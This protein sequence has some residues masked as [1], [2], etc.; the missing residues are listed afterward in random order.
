MA[1]DADLDQPEQPVGDKQDQEAADFV[2]DKN[3]A[4]N[5]QGK[6]ATDQ[7]ENDDAEK[8]EEVKD[9][10]VDDEA[11]DRRM[12]EDQDDDGKKE[13]GAQMEEEKIERTQAQFKESGVLKPESNEKKDQNEEDEE[14]KDEEPSDAI[15]DPRDLIEEYDSY[16][17]DKAEQQRLAKEAEDSE[18]ENDEL[19]TKEDLLRFNQ[20]LERFDYM[21]Q[22]QLIRNRFHEWLSDERE[23][24]QALKLLGKFKNQTQQVS[25]SLCEQLRIVLEPQLS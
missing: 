22:K 25:S 18:M 7:V 13:D 6:L 12:D 3:Q 21:D 5:V 11:E 4:E 20:T 16:L 15:V 14:M 8:E 19:A 9:D 2:F 10:R 1:D 24:S 17:K 23:H